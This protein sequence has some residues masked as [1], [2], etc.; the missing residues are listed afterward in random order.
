M[1]EKVLTKYEVMA[2]LKYKSVRGF[3]S[4]VS[5]PQISLKAFR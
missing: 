2:A 1:N 5:E 3:T 4:S